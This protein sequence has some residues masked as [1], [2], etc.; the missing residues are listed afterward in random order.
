VIRP[1]ET[2][3]RFHPAW[4]PVPSANLAAAVEQT[5]LREQVERTISLHC[6]GA[7]AFATGSC[8]QA[9]ELAALTLGI[10]PGDEVIVPS[11]TYPSTAGAFVLRGAVPRFCDVREDTLN[12][13]VDHLRTLVTARTRAIVAVHYG[14]CP[15]DM[16]EIADVARR[17]DAALIEDAAHAFGSRQDGRALGTIGNIG[18]LSFHRTKGTSCGEGGALL[19]SNPRLDLDAIRRRMAKGVDYDRFLRGEVPHYSWVVAGSNFA[20]SNLHAAVLQERLLGHDE[21]LRART[22]AFAYYRQHLSE[23]GARRGVALPP[24]P[25]ETRSSEIFYLIPP[26]EA[27]SRLMAG[28]LAQAGVE[29]ASH[30][31]PL[32]LSPMGRSLGAR[33]GDCPIAEQV[34][35]RLLRLP[36]HHTLTQD[37]QDHVISS[38]TEGVF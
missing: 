12:L 36:L 15:C 17:A 14:G 33:P 13:D 4:D 2:T 8:T 19:A 22:A 23:W 38:L 29:T 31:R 34:A 1:S 21:R 27:M 5:G 26:D 16:R 28:Q 7:P 3:V 35:A 32:H 9:L 10:G 18:V 11:F 24:E 37:E 25:D 30:Y 20:M 6:D